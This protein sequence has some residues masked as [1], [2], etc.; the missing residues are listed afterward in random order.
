MLAVCQFSRCVNLRVSSS[1]FAVLF[2]SVC[3]RKES[4]SDELVSAA[5]IG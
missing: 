2:S 5:F 3:E 1:E 4:V